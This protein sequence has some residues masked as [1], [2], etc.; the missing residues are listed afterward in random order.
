MGCVVESVGEIGNVFYKAMEEK[1]PTT[2][3]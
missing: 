1:I 3:K 2:L